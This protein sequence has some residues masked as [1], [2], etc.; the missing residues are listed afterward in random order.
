MLE[1]KIFRIKPDRGVLLPGESASVELIYCHIHNSVGLDPGQDEVPILLS[2]AG[3]KQVI[4]TLR[5]RTLSTSDLYLHFHSLVHTFPP[6][7]IGLIQPPIQTYTLYNDSSSEVAFIFD[8]EPLRLMQQ[9]NYD[10][11]VIE[12][13][14]ESGIIPP[15]EQF[16]TQWR[17][18]PLEDKEYICKVPITVQGGS[19]TTLTIQGQGYHPHHAP[20]VATL[21]ADEEILP[22]AQPALVLAGQPAKLSLE[23][24]SLGMR[25]FN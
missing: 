8:T 6:L 11:P 22:P 5:G 24:I 9:E 21:D 4:I 20:N 18:T 15:K 17:F 7:P 14:T 23:R 25:S 12:C 16:T 3:G 1:N 2:I 10:F 19:T 13:I